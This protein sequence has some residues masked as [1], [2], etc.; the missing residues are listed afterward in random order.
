M[1]RFIPILAALT[2]AFVAT[3]AMAQDDPARMQEQQQ[4]CETDV[5][6]FCNDAMPDHDRIA[7]CLRKHWSQISQACRRVMSGHRRRHRSDV[8]HRGE[9]DS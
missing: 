2:L 5:Y 9:G 8:M 3:T 4:A 1:K 7:A 6:T